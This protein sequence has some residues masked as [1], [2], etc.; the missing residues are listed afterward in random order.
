MILFKKQEYS[1][2]VIA[3][4]IFFSAASADEFHYNNVIIGD[5]AGGMGGAYTA[6]SDDASGLFYNPAGIVFGEESKLSASVNAFHTTSTT[7][8]GVLGGGDW[9]RDSSALVPNFFG[10]SQKMGDGYVG[11]SYA[12]TD[13]VIENQDS[14]FTTVVNIPEFIVNVNNQDTTT[15]IGPSYALALSD[16]LNFGITLYFHK[17]ERE[18]IQNQWVKR[19]DNSF[20]WSNL[21]YESSESGVNPVIGFLWS[22][23]DN[24]SF[25]LTIRKPV[26]SSSSSTTQNTCISDINSPTTQP[27]QCIPILGVPKDPQLVT[28]EVK[29]KMPTNIRLGIAY[30]PTNL[31]LVDLDLSYYEATTDDITDRKATLNIAVGLEYYMTQEWVV[32]GGVFTNNSNTPELSSVDTD[33]NDHIDLN[34]FSLSFTRFTKENSFSFGFTSTSGDGEAQVISGVTDIQQVEQSSNTFFISNSYKL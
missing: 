3:T 32:R 28:S 26:I 24:T 17:R 30:F 33:Q 9:T 14:R 5:R 25:G 15:L 27:A 29:R 23:S 19:S 1:G 8:K 16:T 6:I 13:S 11:F 2:V 12:V 4:C 21:Y 7:Y 18:L 34:G 31:F 22:P 20:E 10:V